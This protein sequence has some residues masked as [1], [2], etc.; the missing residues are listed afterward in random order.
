MTNIQEQ[1]YV[2]PSRWIELSE[3]IQHSGEVSDF[4][5]EVYRKDGST[6][7]ISE[8]ARAVCDVKGEV[9]YDQGFVEDITHRKLAENQR[10]SLTTELFQ[11]NQAFSRFVPR[12]FLQ[13]LGK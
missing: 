8:K 3:L 1:L 11:V 6:I 12:Q 5:S 4:E 9:I 13:L 2:N 7:W 10:L